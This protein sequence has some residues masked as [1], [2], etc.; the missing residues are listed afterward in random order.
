MPF[1]F[2]STVI[3]R[4]RTVI[5]SIRQSLRKGL[6]L[7]LISLLISIGIVSLGLQTKASAAQTV[8]LKYRD[9]RVSVPIE[10]LNDLPAA[11]QTSEDLSA[12]LEQ[13]PLTVETIDRYLKDDIP[14]VGIPLSPDQALFVGI[15]LN[16]TIG[17]PLGRESLPQLGEALAKSFQDDQAITFSEIAQNYPDNQ[18]GI[19]LSS[20]QQLHSD[21]HV[22]ITKI[23]PILGAVDY[24]LPE[25]VCNCE[26][27][28]RLTP[29]PE[30]LLQQQNIAS[31]PQADLLLATAVQTDFSTCV[32]SEHRAATAAKYAHLR[33]RSSQKFAQVLN[34]SLSNPTQ[35]D[36]MTAPVRSQLVRAELLKANADYAAQFSLVANPAPPRST[37]PALKLSTESDIIAP[38]AEPIAESVIFTF[39]PL[40]PSFKIAD[41]QAFAETSDLP[42][43]WRFYFNVANI[44]AKQFHKA[45]VEEV[46]LDTVQL[47]SV[48]NSLIGEYVLF[49]ASRVVHTPAQTA[50][51][52]AL[53]SAIILSAADDNKI[54]LLELLTHYPAS[55]VIV[56]GLNLV[57][58][59]GNLKHD[60][61]VNTTTAGLE[62]MLLQMQA[63][64]ADHVCA[65]EE[66]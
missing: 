38:T 51:I 22:F 33:D 53:R 32:S 65:C 8:V 12:F 58:F 6:R 26:L 46:E 25:L 31:R 11:S 17:D 47:S 5:Q 30:L 19:D 49:Q 56:E 28:S 36:S 66:S 61:I 35:D 2:L 18:V 27:E 20:L 57:R 45:L 23:Q 13:I 44:D 43:G 14:D 16:K 42:R 41:L 40:R 21:L 63:N 52:Q 4:L 29:V 34:T 54:S 7:V 50:N 15:Q 60:G 64:A 59:T 55:N 10:A 48:F 1:N 24:L 62:S 9:L 39:G 37:A 3:Q